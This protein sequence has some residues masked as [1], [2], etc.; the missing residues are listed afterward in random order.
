MFILKCLKV[1]S[2][3][4]ISLSILIGI[5]GLF[6]FIIIG[7]YYIVYFITGE[8]SDISLIFIGIVQLLI[9]LLLRNIKLEKFI[10]PITENLQQELD[11]LLRKE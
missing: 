7:P 9:F 2:I 1:L 11:I 8:L 4:I 5:L 10:N 6:I 3:F